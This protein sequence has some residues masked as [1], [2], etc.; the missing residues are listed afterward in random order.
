[1]A[2]V[3]S[4]AQNFVSNFGT[5]CNVT[6]YNLLT[7]D[8]HYTTYCSCVMGCTRAAPTQR[9]DLQGIYSIREFN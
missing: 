7:F 3:V 6:D 4:A 5:W 9:F 1:L 2:H 8:N